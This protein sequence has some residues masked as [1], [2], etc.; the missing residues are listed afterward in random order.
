MDFSNI[1]DEDIIFQTKNVRILKPHI[2]KGVLVFTKYNSKYPNI[3]T[4][5]LKSRKKLVEEGIMENNGPSHS[6]IFFRAPYQK[7]NTIDYSSISKELESL[8]L[9]IDSQFMENKVFIRVDPRYT[10]TFSS[11]I[12]D[13][14]TYPEY[15]RKPYMIQNSKKPMVKYFDIIYQNRELIENNSNKKLVPIFNL[16]SSEVTFKKVNYKCHSPYNPYLININS[17]V[18]VETDYLSPNHFVIV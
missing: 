17:E 8:Y 12:R 14:F 6:C 4:N 5:G 11:E 2:K 16:F 3:K 7:P 15:Y 9:D 1:L 18:L 13:I 10:N